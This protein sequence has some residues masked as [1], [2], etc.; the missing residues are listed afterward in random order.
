M[1]QNAARCNAKSA[2]TTLPDIRE[3]LRLAA[4]AGTIHIEESVA[5]A[6]LSARNG[7]AHVS[8]DLVSTYDGVKN[9][10]KVKRECLRV[11]GAM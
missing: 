9:L 7:A 5:K 3:L 11:L 2:I 1:I 8:R 10:A 6:M 4:T